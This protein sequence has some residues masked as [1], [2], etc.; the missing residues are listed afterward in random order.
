MEMVKYFKKIDI[1]SRPPELNVGGTGG[2]KTNTGALLTLVYLAIMAFV[3]I[4]ATSNYLD[5]SSPT[6]TQN[7]LVDPESPK[8]DF[9]DNNIY[10]LV[11]GFYRNESRITIEEGRYY[12]SARML[13]YSYTF[14]ETSKDYDYANEF[15]ELVPCRDSPGATDLQFKLF[16][17]KVKRETIDSFGMCLPMDK[18]DKLYVEGSFTSKKQQYAYLEITPCSAASCATA[19]ELTKIYFITG[20]AQHT[21]DSSRFNDP[22]RVH[23]ENNDIYYVNPSS[24]IQNSVKLRQYQVK[25]QYGFPYSPKTRFDGFEISEIKTKSQG[26]D[27]TKISCTRAEFLDINTVPCQSFIN[28]EFIGNGNRVVYT[29]TYQGILETLG[30]IGGFNEIIYII[31]VFIYQPFY[32]RAFSQTVMNKLFAFNKGKQKG[33]SKKKVHQ[34]E[35]E[36]NSNL[37]CWQKLCYVLQCKGC[38]KR[39]KQEQI[40]KEV[41][42]S[43]MASLEDTL[44]VLQLVRQMNCLKVLTNILFKAYQ[45]K[46]IPLMALNLFQK[47][48]TQRSELKK[49]RRKT[50]TLSSTSLS[51]VSPITDAKDE[52]IVKEASEI[53]LDYDQAL[54]KLVDRKKELEEKRHMTSMKGKELAKPSEEE[55]REGSP[56]FESPR[57]MSI[58]A[59]GRTE[60]KVTTAN[61]VEG[62]ISD[63]SQDNIVESFEMMIDDYCY[64]ILHDSPLVDVKAVI[65]A[66]QTMLKNQATVQMMG[67]TDLEASSPVKTNSKS[68]F[69]RQSIGDDDE[70]PEGRA[71]DGGELQDSERFNL[72]RLVAND[73]I[74]E[75]ELGQIQGEAAN[76]ETR[77]KD[78]DK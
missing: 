33:F 61:G 62:R 72:Q 64:K 59:R 43:G 23:L 44:D 45:Y 70:S 1:L 34:N 14:N 65:V 40:D 11:L 38:R 26:R 54:D 41:E 21:V 25:D 57:R 52:E 39:T 8:I 50:K 5:D 69:F 46:L 53:I 60:S 24:K 75:V 66:H 36:Q 51:Q 67:Q 56:M 15:I 20:F 48:R 27:S 74:E 76:A 12:F 7:F 37:S 32:Y 6:V 58:Q 71:K 19:L 28:I 4:D 10:P 22:V 73:K 63:S 16:K 29:R 17:G 68:R 9:I 78:E 18:R 55:A 42:E 47:R 77:R 30:N 35:P 2:V 31:L 49:A 13:L 3:V